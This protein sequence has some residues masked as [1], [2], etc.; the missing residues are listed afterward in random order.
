MKKVFTLILA[1]TVVFAGFAQVKS[2]SKNDAKKN[3]AT[4]QVTRGMESFE[5]VQSEPNMVRWDFGEGALD[6]TTYDWQTN[7]GAINRTIVWPD[8]KVTF[9]FTIASDEAFSDRGTG[10][11]TYDPNTGEWT[12]LGARIENEKTGFG[13][14]A[15][16]RDNGMVVAAH[17][18]TQCGFYIIE[19]KDNITP[20]SVP[21]AL[22]LDATIDP[23]WPVVMTSGP[24][25][26]IIHIIATGY[27]DSKLYYFRSLDGETWDCQNVVIPF[28]S[29]EYGLD[30][31]SNAAYWME[32]TE[33]N[34]LA[35]VV[36]NAWSDCMVVYSDDNGQTWERKVFW[37]NP[38]VD[39]TIG[40]EDWMLY[41]R[42]ASAV[43]GYQGELC[44]A[45]EYNGTRG[46]ASDEQHSYFPGI[47]GVSF[48]SEHM[49]YRGETALN[50]DP[51]NPLP[52]TPGN[53]FIMD[54][55]Y[56]MEDVHGSTWLYSDATHDMWPEFMGYITPLDADGQPEDPYTATEFNIEDRAL[57]GSYNSGSVAMPVLV[58]IPGSDYDFVAVWSGMDEN[59]MDE[60]GNFYYKLFASY[61]ADGGRTWTRQIQ[62][63]DDF[64]FSYNEFVYTQAAV[65]DN[66]LVIAAQCDE[67]TGT[68]VQ[69]DESESG[70][71]YYIGLTFDLNELFPEA[72]VGVSEVSH[73]THMSLYPNPA[74]DQ[75]NITLNQGADVVIYNIMGQ[76]VMN[77]EGHAGV[78]TIN[79]SELNAGV[80]FISAG[81]DTQKFVVK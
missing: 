39:V 5:N 71:N 70:N 67:E 30:W 62:L 3:A 1:M 48:W 77:V 6:Y 13:S 21:C 51:T 58:K 52:P 36:S 38:G 53:P 46:H 29:D 79:V 60:A 12:P 24:N 63:T 44:V 61:S 66:T 49:P 31:G 76:A 10:I 23:T 78:N 32:T 50:A 37:H 64:Q 75:L 27:S 18:A 41:P 81:S 40:E 26:D 9:A 34:R 69:S 33:D 19:D 7:S 35:F 65:V 43:W 17:T 8:G 59:N 20:N 14:I 42:W 25:R 73:N 4:M 68:F 80:Y 55:A 45:Y 11:G 22:R 54:T 47:G 57:H 16:Y 72:G 15:R 2:V 56:I 28:L 74:V